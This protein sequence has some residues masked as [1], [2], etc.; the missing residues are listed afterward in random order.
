MN[1]S[2]N[3]FEE[4]IT[5]TVDKETAS[6]IDWSRYGVNHADLFTHCV[7]TS[8]CNMSIGRREL[9]SRHLKENPALLA[10]NSS[11]STSDSFQK[12]R[13]SAK[14]SLLYKFIDESGGF[15]VN[16]VDSKHRST[17]DVICNIKNEDK[18]LE[19]QFVQ[20]AIE[21]GFIGVVTGYPI[22]ESLRFSLKNPVLSESISPLIDFMRDF[23]TKNTE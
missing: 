8:D 6:Q 13:T 7:A 23:Q 1:E 22:R 11:N 16:Q 18:D 10:L 17:V 9:L 3:F 2:G 20:K 14:S 5:P 19:A 4:P 12:L 21:S 15:Y